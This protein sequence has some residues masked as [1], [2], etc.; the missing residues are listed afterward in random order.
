MRSYGIT[1]K[2]I[3]SESILLNLK[4]KNGFQGSEKKKYIIIVSHD[5]QLI[6]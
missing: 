5:S 4:P 1:G 6:K 3:G 2:V